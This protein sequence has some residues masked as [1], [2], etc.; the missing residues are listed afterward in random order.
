MMPLMKSLLLLMLD[1][2]DQ[3]TSLLLLFRC[4]GR[5]STLA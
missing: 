4:T 2:G 5:C 3:V 1:T